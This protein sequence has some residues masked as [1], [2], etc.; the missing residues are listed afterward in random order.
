MNIFEYTQNQVTQYPTTTIDI[1]DFDTFNQYDLLNKIEAYTSSKYTKGSY[2]KL[3]RR[4]PFYNITRRLL[5]KQKEAEDIDTKDIQ[6]TTTRPDHYGKALLMTVANKK[7]MKKV[8]FAKTLNELTETRG[9]FGGVLIKKVM[10]DG[11]LEIEVVDWLSTI[12]DPNDIDSGVKIQELKFNPA[13][14]MNMK[15]SGWENVEEA[16]R[17]SS[18]DNVDNTNSDYTTVYV[19]SGV[20]PR[21]MI[22]DDAE[23]FEYSEQLQIITLSKSKDDKGDEKDDGI[24]LYQKE[25]IDK[26]YKYLPYN[27]RSSRSLG[28]GIVES[29][30][31]AQVSINEVVINQKNT[32]DIAGKPIFQQPKGNSAAK[33]IWTSIVDG[34]VI[35]YNQAPMSL[36]QSMPNSLGYNQTIQNSWQSQI[37]GASSVHGVNTGDMPASA[38]FRGMALQNQEANSTFDQKKEEVDIFLREVY[39]DWIIPFLKTWIKKQ[40]FLDAEIPADKLEK[41]LNDFTYN[42]ARKTVNKK[43]QEGVYS[44]LPAGELFPTMALDIEIEQQRLMANMPKDK[45]WT[46]SSKNYLDGIE[47][48]LDIIITDEQRIKQVYVSNQ[49]DLLNSYLA[50]REAFTADPN[51]MKMYNAIQETLGQEPLEAIDQPI[52]QQEAEPQSQAPV[53]VTNEQ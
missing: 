43:Y 35:E 14:L 15:S 9:K 8:N 16:L 33:N 3:G 22:N 12:T 26:A 20:L 44:D 4:K 32:M 48:D 25:G 29:S 39:I 19:V 42:L 53:A 40:E 10:V 46:K 17:M 7:W 49:I 52:T 50:N 1:G 34:D 6:L 5:N 30:I 45:L 23:E 36:I 31:E 11:M 28:E 38:T 51:A 21:S 47:F 41:V 27:K 24:I 13:E 2:D 18:E 37:D